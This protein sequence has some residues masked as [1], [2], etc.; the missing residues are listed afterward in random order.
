MSAL[1]VG[2]NVFVDGDLTRLGLFHSVN[3]RKNVDLTTEYHMLELVYTFRWD[4]GGICYH[5][6][7]IG[8]LLPP[9]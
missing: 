8:K 3:D 4:M 5:P 2:D 9:E 7:V 6:L 1:M